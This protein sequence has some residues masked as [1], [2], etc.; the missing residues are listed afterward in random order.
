M[1]ATTATATGGGGRRVRIAEIT[2]EIEFD[3]G[4][5]CTKN[6]HASRTILQVKYTYVNLFFMNK[7]HVLNLYIIIINNYILPTTSIRGRVANGIIV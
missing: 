3:I 4:T 6:E 2:S 5:P 1:W 7:C